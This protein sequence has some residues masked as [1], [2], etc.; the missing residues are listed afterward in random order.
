MNHLD[1]EKD[2]IID[3][4]G[5]LNQRA[6]GVGLSVGLRGMES[7][8]NIAS[9]ESKG[10]YLY[11]YYISGTP[12]IIDEDVSPIARWSIRHLNTPKTHYL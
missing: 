1:K 10:G 4:I 2:V 5:K 11:Q 7:Y 6:I 8:N 12:L 3:L 9:Y